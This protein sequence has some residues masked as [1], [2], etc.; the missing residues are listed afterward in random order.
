MVNVRLDPGSA[1]RCDNCG[2]WWGSQIGQRNKTRF[3]QQLP[4]R[5]AENLP[6]DEYRGWHENSDHARECPQ[7]QRITG[8]LI[9]SVR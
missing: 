7:C 9:Y 8:R 2:V 4:I 1:Y 3:L 5:V 6:W